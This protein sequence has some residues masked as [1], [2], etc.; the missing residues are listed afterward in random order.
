M[1]P[2]AANRGS[3]YCVAPVQRSLPSW[4]GAPGEMSIS[5]RWSRIFTL[6]ASSSDLC[7]TGESSSSHIIRVY[8]ACSLRVMSC[9]TFCPGRRWTLVPG[10]ASSSYHRRT[11]RAGW[12]WASSSSELCTDQPLILRPLATR[13]RNAFRLCLVETSPPRCVITSLL[14]QQP[15]LLCQLRAY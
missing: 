10:V 4:S 9:S 11:C 1:A 12:G 2:L 15:L 8:R 7:W 14:S 5:R 13:T 3:R 6:R